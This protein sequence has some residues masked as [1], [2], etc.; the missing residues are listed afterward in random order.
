MR[1]CSVDSTATPPSELRKQITDL[2]DELQE[3]HVFHDLEIKVLQEEYLSDDSKSGI[4]E[5]EYFY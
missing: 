2:R 1:R 3:T 5:V 4:D